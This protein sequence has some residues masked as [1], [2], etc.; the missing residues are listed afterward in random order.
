M[1]IIYIILDVV[2]PD[3][4]SQQFFGLVDFPFSEFTKNVER[5]SLYKL[6]VKK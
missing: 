3:W 4:I 1:I 5:D 2:V 6:Q